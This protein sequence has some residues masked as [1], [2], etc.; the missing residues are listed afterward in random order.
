MPQGDLLP[1]GLWSLVPFWGLADKVMQ[2]GGSNGVWLLQKR[3]KRNEKRGKRTEEKRVKIR[4]RKE[5]K[6]RKRKR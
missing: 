4:Q 1:D 5:N 3:A 2:V 6:K